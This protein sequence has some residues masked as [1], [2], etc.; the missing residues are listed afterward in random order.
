MPEA[1]ILI[2]DDTRAN[3]IALE[4]L[5]KPAAASPVRATSGEEALR[6]ASSLDHIAL[7]LLDLHMPNIDGF[8]VARRLQENDRSRS[9]PI[10]FI[11]AS[12]DDIYIEEA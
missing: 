8:E 5:L 6:L 2:V 11:T 9:I 3:L 1:R 7:I 4:V 10:I 12:Q